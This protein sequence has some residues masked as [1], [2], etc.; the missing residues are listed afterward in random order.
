MRIMPDITSESLGVTTAKVGFLETPLRVPQ[1][2]PVRAGLKQRAQSGCA[3]FLNACF[4]AREKQVFGILMYHRT[5]PEPAGRPKPTWNVRPKRL[6][7]QLAGLLARGWQAWPLRQVLSCAQRELPIPRKTFV[8]TFDD[9]YAN[10]LI[11]AAPIL[12]RLHVPA[13]VFVATAYLDSK[14]PFPS[15]DWPPAGQPGVPSETWR[16][17]T[18]EE[19]GRLSANGLFELGAHTHTHADFRGQREAFASD[20]RQN[21]TVLRER[22]GVE[23]PAFAFPYGTK[24]D[25]F[26]SNELAQAAREVGVTS[27]LT[28]EAEL[29]R[30]GDSPFGWGRFPVEDHDTAATLA[31]K[32]GGWHSALRRLRNAALPSARGHV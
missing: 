7:Q 27:A 10:N 13:T 26:A 2:K 17:L 6:D 3:A 19:C 32:L 16:P 4:G 22:F 12:T 24:I 23:Q 18:T 20:L 28:T 31:G 8:V 29:V 5:A 14:Q 1:G 11:H 9:G 25:G 30:A 15:D 21:L